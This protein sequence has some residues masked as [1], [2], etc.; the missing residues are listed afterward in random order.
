MRMKN[1]SCCCYCCVCFLSVPCM[2][3]VWAEVVWEI[4]VAEIGAWGS[5]SA[6]V[7]RRMLRAARLGPGYGCGDVIAES[8]LMAL[9]CVVGR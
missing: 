8:L 9:G 7:V 3:L 1:W 4:V 5:A 2:R 6:A